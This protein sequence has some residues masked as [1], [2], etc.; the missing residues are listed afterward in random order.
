MLMRGSYNVKHSCVIFVDRMGQNVLDT[1]NFIFLCIQ[2]KY[3][4]HCSKYFPTLLVIHNCIL[5]HCTAHS[6]IAIK[7]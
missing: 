1:L 7:C 6:Q 4:S 2:K 3:K 5:E